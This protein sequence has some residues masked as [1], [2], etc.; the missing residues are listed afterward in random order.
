[1]NFREDV[2]YEDAGASG[3]L[4]G[5]WPEAACAEVGPEKRLR[6]SMC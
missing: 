2:P 5:G 4:A 1:M 3:E 6:L